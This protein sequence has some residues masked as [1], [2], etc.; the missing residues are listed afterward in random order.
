[1][2][3]RIRPSRSNVASATGSRSQKSSTFCKTNVLRFGSMLPIVSLL[4]SSLVCAEVAPVTAFATEA[5][6]WVGQRL[7]FYI[8]LHAPGLFA[9]TASFD[10][11]QLPGTL[12]V[13]IGEPVVSSQQLEDET[14]FVQTH[15]FALF[16]QKP[17]MLEVPPINVRFARRE[18]FTGPAIDVQAKSPSLTVE[19]QRPPGSEKIGFLITT[20]SLDV[21]ETWEPTPGPADVGAIF[22]RTI[23]QRAQQLPGMALAPAPVISPEGIRSYIGN[24]T[25][26]DKL[27]RGEFLGE[28]RESI[29]YLVQKSGTLE[30]PAINYVW[31]NPKTEA[32]QSKTLPAVTFQVTPPPATVTKT[33]IVTRDVW[34]WMLTAT[35]F[36]GL[37]LWQWRRVVTWGRQNWNELNPPDRIAGRQ[38]LRA[39][40][41]HD[42]TAAQTAWGGWRNTQDATF[43]PAPEFDAAII[44]LQRH[45][46]GPSPA[47]SWKG[48]ELARAFKAHLTTAT[49]RTCEESTSIL[50]LLNP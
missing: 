35:L 46:F 36:L 26:N 29:T 43:Q 9:G 34:P 14:W 1:M 33:P 47:A 24:T 44:A 4:W 30:L 8:E 5:K 28:R 16:S 45:L 23:V 19:I 50:P 10:L 31:W 11:P 13:K 40:R 18:G 48:E 6:S 22:K 7:P 37:S 27:A 38:L 12:L 39:C 20:E 17:G 3:A 2:T 25:T 42:A 41:N 49:T 15:E 32:L 21:T